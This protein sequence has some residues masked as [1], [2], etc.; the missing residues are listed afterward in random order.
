MALALIAIS[1]N[2]AVKGDVNNDGE[3][4]I[5]DVNAVI[6]MILTGEPDLIGDVNNDGEINIADVNAVIDIIWALMRNSLMTGQ[7]LAAISRC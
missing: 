3:V 1:A 2:A 5:A 6:N 7:W 4:N